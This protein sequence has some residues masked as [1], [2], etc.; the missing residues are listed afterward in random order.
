M[1]I[2]TYLRKTEK[3]IIKLDRVQSNFL[4]QKI[5]KFEFLTPNRITFIGLLFELVSIFLFLFRD[6][7]W[8]LIACLIL[9]FVGILDFLDGDLA[10]LN[11]SLADVFIFY[12]C[13]M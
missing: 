5:K 3:I 11:N 12:F 9:Y 10:R 4:L 7:L 2:L 8:S 1:K 6:Y 13:Y